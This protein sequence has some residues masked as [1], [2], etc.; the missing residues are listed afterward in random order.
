MK[1]S[2]LT[3]T[4]LLSMSSL[5]Q[6]AAVF[7]SA[8]IQYVF[9]GYPDRAVSLVPIG[10]AVNPAGCTSDAAYIID[11]YHDSHGA[12]QILLAAK[13]SGS[14]VHFSVRDDVCHHVKQTDVQ[15]MTVP[16]I[17]RIGF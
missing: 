11:R 5:S 9:G 15:G 13:Q 17:Q 7:T 10:V 6:A 16:I 1:R 8:Q 4:V 12:L 3:A 14:T 2:I